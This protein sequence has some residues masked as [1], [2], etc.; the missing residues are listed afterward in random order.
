ML[1]KCVMLIDEIYISHD[2]AKSHYFINQNTLCNIML[3]CKRCWI[4]FISIG[5]HQRFQSPLSQIGM[6]HFAMKGLNVLFRSSHHLSTFTNQF[7][8]SSKPVT[9][10]SARVA[11]CFTSSQL[12]IEY[13]YFV[14][15]DVMPCKDSDW[16]TLSEQFA[17]RRMVIAFT[18][19]KDKEKWCKILE[20][21]QVILN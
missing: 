4:V 2:K 14:K 18:E 19:D 9:N 13:S 10:A 6:R 15:S 12:Q 16:M 5:F 21:M 11:G 17:S 8:H 7:I 3:H 1:S 20:A